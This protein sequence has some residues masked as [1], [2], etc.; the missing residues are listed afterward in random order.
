MLGIVIPVYRP[1]DLERTVSWVRE[2]VTVPHHIVIVEHWRG[3]PTI[4]R[5]DCTHLQVRRAH[6]YPERGSGSRIGIEYLLKDSRV[7]V[8][9]EVDA[10]CTDDIRDIDDCYNSIL[11]DSHVI[12]KSRRLLTSKQ[13]RPWVRRCVTHT[14]GR[15]TELLL[16]G[17]IQD[18]SYTHRYYPVEALHTHGLPRTTGL[19]THMWNFAL[20]VH[21]WDSGVRIHE[22]SAT[23]RDYVRSSIRPQH[24]ARYCWEYAKVL[25]QR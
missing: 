16:Q 11:L 17:G 23:Q 25:C 8:I 3:S 2:H 12:I 4:R 14:F 21:L 15:V 18:W 24:L 1:P 13:H 6:R 10:D 20:L 22:R 19:H 9:T 5:T 7:R